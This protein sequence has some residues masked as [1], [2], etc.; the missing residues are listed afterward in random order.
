MP[1]KL[2]GWALGIFM[3]LAGPLAF[4]YGGYW[5]GVDRPGWTWAVGPCPFC[6]HLGIG[7]GAKVALARL[8][9]QE[10]AAA[11]HAKQ[12]QTAQTSISARAAQIEADSQTKI[13]TTYR[14]I[15]QEIPVALPP[16]ADPLLPR[17]WV[18][19]HDEAVDGVPAVSNTPSQSDEAASDIR[20]SVALGTVVGNYGS[21][22]E[23]SERLSALQAWV[24]A[25]Q[26]ASK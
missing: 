17:Y 14:T 2:I 11:L 13:V 8:Q 12:V 9:A 25:E 4:A 19:I 6:L 24:T 21:C 22:G 20:A 3:A 15:R 1:G 23:T 10:A 16:A 5:W 18:R 26:G 7:P